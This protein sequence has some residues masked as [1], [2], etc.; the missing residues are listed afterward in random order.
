MSATGSY[1]EIFAEF[2]VGV[3]EFEF[4]W[5]FIKPL[6]NNILSLANLLEVSIA[7][8]PTLFVKGDLESWDKATKY[9]A[10]NV[11]NLKAFVQHL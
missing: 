7:N 9:M 1:Q 11:P 3:K 2:I 10:S 5:Y 4:Q 8:L 6:Q